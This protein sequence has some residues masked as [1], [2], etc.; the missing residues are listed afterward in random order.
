MRGALTGSLLLIVIIKL[1]FFLGLPAFAQYVAEG[2]III[3]AMGA[4]LLRRRGE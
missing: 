2:L 3:A 4:H 1:M